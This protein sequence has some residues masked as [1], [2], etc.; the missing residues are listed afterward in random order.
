ME[1]D[2]LLTH[3]IT[4]LLNQLGQTWHSTIPASAFMQ[5]TPLSYCEGEFQATAPI[6]PNI[7]LHQTMFAG[8]I[9]TLMTLTGWGAVW[10]NQRLAGV[11]GDIVLADAH[12]RYLAPVTCN[13]VAKVQWPEVDL[14]PLERGRRIKL[15]LEVLLYCG[16]GLC[17]VFEGLYVSA[18]KVA[19]AVSTIKVI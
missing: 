10:L 13:P 9:Y 7:N 14:C 6:E 1:R 3:T 11:T 15:K 19:L 8:S 2:K 18:P 17:A 5:I 16:N 4:Q 12:I